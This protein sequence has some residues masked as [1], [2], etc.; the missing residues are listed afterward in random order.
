MCTA[1]IFGSERTTIAD[2]PPL[3]RDVRGVIEKFRG[4]RGFYK[5]TA[6]VK[7]APPVLRNLLDRYATFTGSAI[8][9]AFTGSA[10]GIF[11]EK[12]WAVRRKNL[13]HSKKVSPAASLIV[14]IG[15]GLSPR[16]FLY[17]VNKIIAKLH[18]SYI[19]IESP[20]QVLYLREKSFVVQGSIIVFRIG[21]EPCYRTELRQLSDMKFMERGSY[22][23]DPSNIKLTR[24][25]TVFALKD[26]RVNIYL[27]ETYFQSKVKILSLPTKE[28]VTAFGVSADGR[29]ILTGGIDG[30]RR[31]ELQETKSIQKI[32]KELSAEDK[33]KKD[34]EK[35]VPTI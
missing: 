7:P 33:A 20:P 25:N 13:A 30:I 15:L 1:M 11:L 27:S 10:I 26:G 18:E 34:I 8:D 14:G 35:F 12:A 3:N 32:I 16:L 4:G 22:P 5:Q 24:N 29:I 21:D 28:K 6:H 9:V 31:W 2:L 19:Y 17:L 23:K